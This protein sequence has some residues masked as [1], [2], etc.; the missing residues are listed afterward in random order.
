MLEAEGRQ[1]ADAREE[2][3][4]EFS[5][6]DIGRLLS[7]TDTVDSFIFFFSCYFWLFY[8]SGLTMKVQHATSLGISMG[9]SEDW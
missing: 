9:E 1:L 3:A 7:L 2:I 8:L 4:S 6:P 5:I